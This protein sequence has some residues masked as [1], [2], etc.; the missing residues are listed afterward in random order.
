MTTENDS[1]S[2]LDLFEAE[3]TGQ[4]TEKV[5][6]VP[7][8]FKGKS[9]EDMI[10]SYQNLEK[11][12]SRQASELG[13]VRR[14]A[15]QLLELK[16]PTTEQK[17]VERQPVTVET[18]LNDPEKALR[19]AVD[20]SDMAQRAQ[21]AEEAVQ[22]LERKI[23]EKDFVSK[24]EGFAEDMSNP[25]FISWTQK[26]PARA[27]LGQH[28]ANGDYVAADSLWQM[29]DEHKELVGAKDTKPASSAKKVPSGVK[30]APLG[31]SPKQNYSRAKLMEL[32]MK[33]QNG[34]EAATARWMDASFQ[35]KLIKAYEEGRVV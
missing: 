7:D 35:E 23:S 34:D 4:T 26:N 19:S 25:E 10:Q 27:V 33:V 2:D 28:A 18:L 8:K 20:S 3:A 22:R 11:L 13:Q 12:Q 6:T 1:A 15:D 29:W 14:M 17:I 9:V 24:H 30:Q 16:K 5:T 31:S 21:R 32:R